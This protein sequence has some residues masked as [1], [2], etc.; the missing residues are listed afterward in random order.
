[1][2]GLAQKRL[3][4]G[5]GRE[6]ARLAFDAELALETAVARNQANDGLERWMLRLSQ[7]MSQ[8]VLGATPLS[9]L[10]RNRA[11]SFSVRVLPIMPSTLPVA[12]L[13]AAI[14]V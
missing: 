11:K 13:K 9:K 4:G 3:A 1:M 14:R 10:R 2:I 7:T 6:H 5:L 8:R 12:T